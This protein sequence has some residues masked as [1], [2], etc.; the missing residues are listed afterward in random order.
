MTDEET[1]ETFQPSL[2]VLIENEDVILERSESIIDAVDTAVN[3]R[4]DRVPGGQII[5]KVATSLGV[6]NGEDT[7]QEIAE[8]LVGHILVSS[9][10]EREIIDSGGTEQLANLLSDLQVKFSSEMSRLQTID[11]RGEDWWVSVDSEVVLKSGAFIF[12]HEFELASGEVIKYRSS[13]SSDLFL[14]KHKLSEIEELIEEVGTDTIEQEDVKELTA[15]NK[16][17]ESTVELLEENGVEVSTPPSDSETDEA[18]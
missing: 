13:I 10:S 3:S 9:K 8:A 4:S 12:A 5:D 18:R 11:V 6:E 16:A 7:N 17:I 15:I 1:D 14:I 2:E